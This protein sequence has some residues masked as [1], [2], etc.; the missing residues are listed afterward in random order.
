M[1]NYFKVENIRNCS[2]KKLCSLNMPIEEAEVLVDSMLAAD[3]SGISTHG[4]RMLPSYIEKIRR[5]DFSFGTPEIKKQ[6]AA[7]TVIDAKN[8]VGAVSATYAQNIAVDKAFLSGIHTVFSKNS[9]TFGPAFYYVEKIAEKG[10][11]G[12]TCCNSP[13]AMPAYNGLEVMLGTNPLAFAAPS[14]T[15]GNI[16]IDMATS[17]VAKSRFGVAK[18]NGE[19]LQPG[20]ALDKDGNPT[21][22]PEEAMKGFIL[23]MA[24]FK[25]YGI[26]LIIDILSGLLSGAGYLNNVGKFYSDCGAPMNVGHMIVAINPDIVYD[27]DFA[28]EL[29]SYITKL[30]NS[31]KMTGKEIVIPGDRR[32]KIIKRSSVSG[33]ELPEEIVK[34][35]EIIFGEKLKVATL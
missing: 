28:A 6:T 13:A 14:K 19:K 20:W 4:I 15:C 35:L 16:V 31:K 8:I 34:K 3:M 32:A 33:I 30:R 11:I 22:D 17:V 7:F 1:S 5:K 2:V 29:D 27:G 26:A 10:M 12:F 9:N 24:G 23:P 25:G 21:I 18:E